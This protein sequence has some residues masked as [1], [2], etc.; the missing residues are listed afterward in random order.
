[1]IQAHCLCT[2][3]HLATLTYL[4]NLYNTDLRTHLC[5]MPNSLWLKN[6]KDVGYADSCLMSVVTLLN[7]L[8]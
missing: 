1:M 4:R 7:V 3:S 8:Q 2:D 6:R 5:F